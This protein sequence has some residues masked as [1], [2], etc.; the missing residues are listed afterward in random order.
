MQ[1]VFRTSFEEGYYDYQGVLQLT[2]PTGWTPRWIDGAASAVLHRPEYDVKDRERGHRETR[3]GR[4]SASFYTVFATHDA[5]LYRKFRVAPDKLVRA[6]V[7][8][9]NVSNSRG[10]RDG[11]HG[12]RIG[13]DPSGG[14][15][16]TASSVV[17]GGWWSSYMPDWEERQWRE[18]AVETSSEAEVVT[19]FLHAKCDYAADI[20]ASYWDDFQLQVG[21]AA[22]VPLPDEGRTYPTL[23]QIE[24]VVRRVVREELSKLREG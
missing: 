3:T 20:N 23:A 18:L 16:H 2:C 1:T 7:W 6:T 10:G 5:C 9:M 13:I 14:E 11:G 4:F 19:V 22:P 24:D 15:D 21:E 17:Y 12:M 8:G